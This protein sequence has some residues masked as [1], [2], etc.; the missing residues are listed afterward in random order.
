MSFFLCLGRAM[1]MSA[2]T[3]R[4][5]RRATRANPWCEPLECRQ[6][7]SSASSSAITAETNIAV[8]KAV[9]SGPTGLTPAEIRAAYGVNLIA[10]DDG[11][12]TGDGAGETIAIVDAYLDPSI[13]ADLAVFDQEYGLAAPPSF[14][15][16]NL[17]ATRTD[18]GWA[19][20][21]ALDVE[22]AHAIAPNANIVLVEAASSSLNSLLGAVSY[23]AKQPGVSVVSMSW[24]TSEFRGETNYNSVFTTPA[25][26]AGVAFVA[27]SGD[28]G[29][30]D[31]PEFPSV[32]P[33]VVAVGG[34]TLTLTAAGTYA[35]ETGWSGSTGGFSGTDSNFTT[36]ETE[37]SYQVSALESAGLSDGVRTTPDVAFNADP[38]SGVSV[39]DSSGYDGES[40]W[41]QL[42]G[43]SAAAPAWAGLIAIA[44][45]GLAIAGKGPLTST[46]VLTDLYS[47]P[48]TDFN[49]ITS[50]YNGY[51]ATAG[52]NL[53]TGLGSPKS[54]LV[55]AGILAENG[56]SESA[57]TAAST[58][59]SATRTPVAASSPTSSKHTVHH[60]HVAHKT[61][62]TKHTKVRH[63][64]V[65]STSNKVSAGEDESL[66]SQPASIL[67]EEELMPTASIH[68]SSYDRLLRE[69]RSISRSAERDWD[70]FDEALAQVADSAAL[71]LKPSRQAL[72]HRPAAN[73]AEHDLTIEFLPT[74]PT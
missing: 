49:E 69:I 23:A 31:G 5:R 15:V 54:A 2:A 13:A 41:F 58:N 20:E 29:A 67:E 8:T 33:D 21:T 51:Y 3:E 68:D 46:E 26:H 60:K 24:G 56:V 12:S 70:E 72:G 35:Y 52:Y 36:D 22:W 55:V 63:A 6:L 7:L 53:V 37:P 45:Q 74:S 48:S 1:G 9:S 42:G 71:R 47:L 43:T 4:Q 11:T 73:A 27:A 18:P 30:A 17:G 64:V 34:T 28:T 32:A 44:D 10:F 61:K 65:Q 19:L 50:G 66:T 14:A 40:G 59:S 62:K 57:S 25:G 39:Y 16:V 38:N